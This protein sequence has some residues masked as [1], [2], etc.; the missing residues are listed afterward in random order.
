VVSNGVKLK[1]DGKVTYEKNNILDVKI[2]EDLV[3]VFENIDVKR[4]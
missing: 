1:C 4:R 3:E 2:D